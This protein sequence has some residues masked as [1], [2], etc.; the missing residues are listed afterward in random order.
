MAS[1]RFV[2]V[3]LVGF[4]VIAVENHCDAQQLRRYSTPYVAPA[5][6]TISPYMNLFRND[7]G[8]MF[9]PY[10]Q[11]VQPAQQAQSRLEQAARRTNAQFSQLRSEVGQLQGDMRQVRESGAAPTGVGARYMNYGQYFQS[12]MGVGPS[13][14][15]AGRARGR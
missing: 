14:G 6:P 2:A 4:A 15:G 7:V 1:I 5:G 9:D 12:N 11:Y 13:V 8:A 10:N 3:C